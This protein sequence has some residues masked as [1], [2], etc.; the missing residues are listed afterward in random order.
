MRSLKSSV[1][2]T[3]EIILARENTKRISDVGAHTHT[4]T[5]TRT[6]THTHRV[7]YLLFYLVFF[8]P[9]II[10]FR[11]QLRSLPGK[12]NQKLAKTTYFSVLHDRPIFNDSI[13]TGTSLQI[14]CKI[15]MS[16]RTLTGTFKSP[17]HP[18]S[19]AINEFPINF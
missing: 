13:E 11:G 10:E 17:A 7:G 4:R 3:P 15:Q 18:F 2:E 19:R 14:H 12:C 6:R 5:R 9:L 16:H 8:L 1:S